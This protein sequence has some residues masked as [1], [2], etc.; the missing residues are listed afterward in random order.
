V[1]SIPTRGMDIC[2]ILFCV[3]VVLC[4]GSG[5]ETG[6]SLV[7][8]VCSL[9][10]KDYETEEEARAQQSAVDEWMIDWMNFNVQANRISIS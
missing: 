1:S 6:W 10:K 8:V 5:L 2:V 7:R 3:Y 9:C 4:V